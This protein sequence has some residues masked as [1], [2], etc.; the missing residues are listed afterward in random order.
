VGLAVVGVFGERH[1]LDGEH[2]EHT[3]HEVEDQAAE[4]R[5][6]Q[7]STQR[8]RAGAAHWSGRAR[9]VGVQRGL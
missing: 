9:G 7:G 5:A 6:Q 8:E 4:Q 3:G 1:D 2:R